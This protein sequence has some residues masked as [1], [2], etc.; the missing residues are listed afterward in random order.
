MTHNHQRSNDVDLDNI[1]IY[2]QPHPQP[3]KIKKNLRD[4]LSNV[5]QFKFE[6]RPFVE[7][8]KKI[9]TT[10]KGQPMNYRL[11]ILFTC[12]TYVLWRG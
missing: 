6:H 12:G 1:R 5:K 9:T 11:L 8:K 3:Q 7:P 2:T 4:K 10:N